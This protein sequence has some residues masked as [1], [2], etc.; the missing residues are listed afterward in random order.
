MPFPRANFS[1]LTFA[2]AAIVLSSIAMA[3]ERGSVSEAQKRYQEERAACMQMEAG[4]DRTTCLRETGAALQAA[5][6]GELEKARAEY[7]RNLM[8]RCT[9]LPEPERDECERRM[10]GEGTTTG[11]VEG[12]GIY[13]ELRTIVPAEG[14]D[15][16]AG[17]GASGRTR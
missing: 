14:S 16:S 10:R 9:Y 15:A 17:S 12:G 13:R 1:R 6:R 8:I 5:R 3:A 7:D 2:A 11:S 4:E